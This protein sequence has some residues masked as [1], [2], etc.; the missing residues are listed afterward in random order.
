[1]QN[2]DSGGLQADNCRFSEESQGRN[3]LLIPKRLLLRDDLGEMF[4]NYGFK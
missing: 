2:L 3:A 4:A 1:M